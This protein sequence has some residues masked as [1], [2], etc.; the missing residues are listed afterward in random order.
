MKIWKLSPLDPDFAGWCYS[1]HL[2]DA[3][4]RAEDEE[5]ARDIAALRFRRLIPKKRPCQETPRS[6]WKNPTVVKC[7]ELENSDYSTHGL[8][9]LLEPEPEDF[10]I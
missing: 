2:G 3:I 9:R 8:P 6:L 4:V 7:I 10:N 1:R 5:Q